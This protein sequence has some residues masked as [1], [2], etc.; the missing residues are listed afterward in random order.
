MP[1]KSPVRNHCR[2]RRQPGCSLDTNLAKPARLLSYLLLSALAVTGCAS[3]PAYVRPEVE[4][5]PAYREG[6]PWKEASPAD[7]LPKGPWW[8]IFGDGEL[9]S[10]EERARAANQ[11]LKAA[12]ARIEQ[13]RANVRGVDAG[14]LPS[15]SL[16][17]SAERRRTA[18]DLSPS[19]RAQVTTT[20]RAPLDMS[21]ELDLFGR[22]KRSVEAARSELE[23][24]QADYENLLLSLQAEVADTYIALRTLDSEVQL[25]ERTLKLRGKNYELV[26]TLY[27]NGQVSRLDLARAQS[28]LASASADMAA[29]SRLRAARE[30]SLAVLVGENPSVFS[31]L[32]RALE[33]TGTIPSVSP[34]LPSSLLERRPDIAAAERRL[35]AAN[36]RIGVAEAV[37]FPSISLTGSAGFASDEIGTLFQ[38]ENRTWALGPFLSLPLFDGGRN[39]AGL[40]LARARWEEAV[41][42]YR[43]Q[44]LV[45]FSEVEDA[46]SDLRFLSTQFDALKQA[47]ASA[48][49]AADLTDKRYRA[50]RVSYL[51]VVVSERTALAAEVLAVRALGQ[52]LQ[53]SVILV[54]ALGGGW[55]QDKDTGP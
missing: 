26:K 8:E 39:Q 21:Y 4:I 18:D 28:E 29:A 35:M 6:A 49:Q 27:E 13:A 23:A 55:E 34:G 41:A 32:P 37:F 42:K 25:L 3:G 43:Q 24:S 10:L 52:R 15:I 50:G 33:L 5:S 54:K 45:A 16:N 38:W 19:G 46:L 53:T 31:L 47:V 9:N 12:A 17:P 2:L 51:E 36:S 11:D 40:N 14:R 20:L 22:V 48:R 7:D 44:I 30:H 1:D